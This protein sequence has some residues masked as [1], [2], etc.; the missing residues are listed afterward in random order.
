MPD[1]ISIVVTPIVR[2]APKSTPDTE[3]ILAGDEAKDVGGTVDAP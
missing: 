3:A 1:D 2:H